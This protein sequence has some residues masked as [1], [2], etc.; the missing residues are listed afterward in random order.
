[1]KRN[2]GRWAD[3]IAWFH[4]L[5]L[6][7]IIVLPF[8]PVLFILLGDDSALKQSSNIGYA[9]LIVYLLAIVLL[10][11]G[12]KGCPLTHLENKLR[13]RDSDDYK[14]QE[15]FISY[16]LKRHLGL[17]VP[18]EIVTLAMVVMAVCSAMAGVIWLAYVLAV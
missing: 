7:P 6:L 9:G 16:R 1:M 14:P 2:F 11:F 18:P 8:L 17:N 4:L 10:N 12:F 3:A 15:S 13:S 5:S